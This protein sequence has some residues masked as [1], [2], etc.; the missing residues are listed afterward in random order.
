MLI[1]FATPRSIATDCS[2]SRKLL[3]QDRDGPWT[4]EE[5]QGLID[6]L[7]YLEG[8]VGERRR[9]VFHRHDGAVIVRRGI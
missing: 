7:G 9:E 8:K 6:H 2:V 5:V 3:W 1:L 4:D